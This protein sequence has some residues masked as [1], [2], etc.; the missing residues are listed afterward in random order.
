MRD[1]LA[2]VCAVAMERICFSGFAFV[3]RMRPDQGKKGCLAAEKVLSR[4][5]RRRTALGVLLLFCRHCCA[6]MRSTGQVSR[7]PQST[8][9]S[10]RRHRRSSRVVRR[11]PKPL[12]GWIGRRR[13]P[14]LTA[15]VVF[16]RPFLPRSFIERER[17][18]H[19]PHPRPE[20]NEEKGSSA[21]EARRRRR[22]KNRLMTAHQAG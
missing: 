2:E 5:P 18:G 4:F 22:S 17:G 11:H 8:S 19:Q 20:A 3:G 1:A 12:R 9:S 16:P 10:Q 7:V 21:R 6:A 13:R 15:D 14:P